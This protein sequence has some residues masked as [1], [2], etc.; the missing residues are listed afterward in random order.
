MSHH[1]LEK[2]IEMFRKTSEGLIVLLQEGDPVGIDALARAHDESF[3]RLVKHGPFTNPDDL[4][5]LVDLKEA[6][7]RTRKSLKEGKERL[8]AKIVSSKKKRQCLKAYGN[9]S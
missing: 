6:V 1:D 9:E 3:R 4:Q 2:D 7:D 8:F 5:M